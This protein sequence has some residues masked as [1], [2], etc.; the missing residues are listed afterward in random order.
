[1]SNLLKQNPK[2]ILEKNVQKGRIAEEIAKQDYLDNGFE[3]QKTG[4]GSDFIAEKQNGNTIYKEYVDVKS[5]NAKLTK[6]QR[7]TKN[8]LKK[9][10]INYSVYRVTDEHL[11]FQIENNHKLQQFCEN[12]GYDISQFTGI[13]VIQ[14]PTYCP[15]GDCSNHGLHSHGLDEI[16]NN[17]GLRNMSDGTVRVQS[18]CRNCRNHSRRGRK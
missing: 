7:E 1:M 5:G 11:E 15:N 2:D 6:K 10:K 9:N 14:D 18:W 16:L 13:F 3:I 12:V 8:Q 17:F 4:I